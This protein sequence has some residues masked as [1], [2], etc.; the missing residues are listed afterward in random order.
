M[1]R[2]RIAEL[3]SFDYETGEVFECLDEIKRLRVIVKAQHDWLYRIGKTARHDIAAALF[4]D[5]TCAA[6]AKIASEEGT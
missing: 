3:R 6:G 4:S 5:P 1:T 2:D